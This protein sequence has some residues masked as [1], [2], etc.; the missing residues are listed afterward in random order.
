[1]EDLEAFTAEVR[2][3]Q[4]A[5]IP[6]FLGGQSMGGLVTLTAAARARTPLAGLVLTSA[7]VDI[8]WTPVLRWALRPP[9]P[10]PLY[11]TCTHART[12]A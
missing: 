4:P 10:P 9:P 3:H 6:L 1:M 2:A 12:H 8:E 5:G 7:L 11:H